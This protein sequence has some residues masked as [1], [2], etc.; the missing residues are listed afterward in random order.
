MPNVVFDYRYSPFND[1][2]AG[3][4]GSEEVTP[5]RV[6]ENIGTI[7]RDYSCVIALHCKQVF[8]AELV[9]GIRCINIHPGLNPYNRGWFPHVFSIIN[10]L[11][12]GVTLHEMDKELDHGPIIDQEELKVREMIHLQLFMKG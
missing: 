2:F 10:G 12:V 6:S 7:L 9:K 11:P 8:P 5:M 1:E 3:R 4:F